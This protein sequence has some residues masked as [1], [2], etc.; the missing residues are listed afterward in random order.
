MSERSILDDQIDY[1]RARAGEYDEWWFRTGRYDRGPEWNARWR[2]DVGEVERAVERWLE[3]SRP[4]NALELA[5]GTGLFTRLLA[6]KVGR[7]TAIDASSEVL[8]I[9]RG[10]VAGGNV[11][12]AQADLFAWQPR[13]RYDAVFFSFWLSHVPDE[14]FAPFWK[15]VGTALA[16]GGAAYLVDSAFDPTSTAKDHPSPERDAGIVT[17]RLNDGREFRIVKLFY[18]PAVLAAKLE[19][20]G[21][22]SE[23]GQTAQ[24]FIYG[25]ARP[26]AE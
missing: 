20:V 1:Y 14:R 17:R 23:I 18:E 9:N 22:T 6:P 11:E 8:A 4:Q 10:R 21:F 2:A 7:L 5:C 12:Y 15:M 24:Y 3:A 16:P 26:V 19:R 25:E 13:E